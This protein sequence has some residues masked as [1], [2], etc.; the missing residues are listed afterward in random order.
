MSLRQVRKFTTTQT[1]TILETCRT[2]KIKRT[3]NFPFYLINQLKPSLK[4]KYIITKQHTRER[5]ALHTSLLPFTNSIEKA[6][7]IES[8]DQNVIDEIDE[9]VRYISQHTMVFSTSKSKMISP[10]PCPSVALFRK[11]TKYKS[12]ITQIATKYDCHFWCLE[13][14]NR[15]GLFSTNDHDGKACIMDI[16]RYIDGTKIHLDYVQCDE[17]YKK[18]YFRYSNPSFHKL[19]EHCN[20]K[21]GEDTYDI[22]KRFC[23]KGFVWIWSENDECRQYIKEYI[24]NDLKHH[25]IHQ[26]AHVENYKLSILHGAPHNH[27]DDIGQ[28]I[29]MF[30]RLFKYDAESKLCVYVDEDGQ[31]CLFDYTAVM[32]PKTKEL[33]ICIV[34][35]STYCDSMSSA[36]RCIQKIV[37]RIKNCDDECIELVVGKPYLHILSKCYV[38]RIP[39]DILYAEMEDTLRLTYDEIESFNHFKSLI[40]DHIAPNTIIVEGFECFG[41]AHVFGKLMKNQQMDLKFIQSIK[42]IDDDMFTVVLHDERFMGVEYRRKIEDMI[43][44]VRS[45]EMQRYEVSDA[46][47]FHIIYGWHAQ[48]L[49]A[50]KKHCDLECMGEG[51]IQRDMANKVMHIGLDK[52]D[53]RLKKLVSLFGVIVSNCITVK[54]SPAEWQFLRSNHQ[55]NIRGLTKMFKCCLALDNGK[56]CDRLLLYASQTDT[57]IIVDKIRNLHL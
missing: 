45:N 47:Y 40:F 24:E 20:N 15:L 31:K 11:N 4:S 32:R 50:L 41:E 17:V 48:Q 13:S 35:H 6:L 51:L 3:V 44:N 18:F 26:Y 25:W 5:Q 56:T 43:R 19:I 49:H 28:R 12:D 37:D 38:D 22:E 8:D 36:K 21:F 16:R 42:N 9:T 52:T 34:I 57:E 2:H 33:D 14:D 23:D 29:N 27:D 39:K 54:L 10:N 46:T 53:E 55:W 1:K 30:W 7:N